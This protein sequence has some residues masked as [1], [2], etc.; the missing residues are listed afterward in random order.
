MTPA[1]ISPHRLNA[2]QV[3][4]A[5]APVAQSVEQLPFKERVAGSIP[6]GRTRRN[7]SAKCRFFRTCARRRHVGAEP[8]SRKIS[9]EIYLWPQDHCYLEIEN[10]FSYK[11]Y[12]KP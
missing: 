12:R 4:E 11:I 3:G 7:K 5:N 9:E 1:R 6:A 8:G 10:Y 2:D